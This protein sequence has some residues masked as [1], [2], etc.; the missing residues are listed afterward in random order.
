MYDAL[1]NVVHFHFG[2]SWNKLTLWPNSAVH[3]VSINQETLLLAAAVS[4]QHIHRVDGIF[5]HPLDVHKLHSKSSIHHHVSKEICI[6][7]GSRLRQIRGFIALTISLQS[8]GIQRPAIK[9]VWSTCALCRKKDTFQW[10][11]RTWRS[12]LHWL[13]TLCPVPLFQ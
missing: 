10:F 13:S 6:T 9:W 5:G 1:H 11:W 4:F 12:W 7:E 2:I 3:C 8:P